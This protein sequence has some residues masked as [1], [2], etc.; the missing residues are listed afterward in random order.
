[1]T[2]LK[3]TPGSPLS[4]SAEIAA[5][6]EF[7]YSMTTSMAESIDH[8][9]RNVAWCLPKGS[10]SSSHREILGKI[11]TEEVPYSNLGYYSKDL[12]DQEYNNM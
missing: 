4:M 3:M 1:M 6:S 9:G 7:M 11:A 12:L 2:A 8:K 5:G 10:Q